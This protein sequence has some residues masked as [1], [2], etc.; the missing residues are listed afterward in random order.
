MSAAFTAFAFVLIPLLRLGDKRVKE[1]PRAQCPPVGRRAIT[2]CAAVVES[3]LRQ[4]REMPRCENSSSRRHDRGHRKALK[5]RRRPALI[6]IKAADATLSKIPRAPTARPRNPS[7]MWR[8]AA[9]HYGGKV[10]L[11]AGP[12]PFA[13]DNHQPGS[14]QPSAPSPRNPMPGPLRT[15]RTQMAPAVLVQRNCRLSER[16]RPRVPANSLPTNLGQ[17]S[18]AAGSGGVGRSWLA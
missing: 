6:E 13:A 10:F 16:R 3:E 2:S 5:R 7:S 8:A 14:P 4:S 17:R 9:R 1:Y 15:M 12:D 11:R 18:R